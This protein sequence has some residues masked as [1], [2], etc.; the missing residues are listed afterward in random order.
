MADLTDIDEILEYLATIGISH[1]KYYNAVSLIS[2]YYQNDICYII[3]LIG[4]Y[5]KLYISHEYY[6][7][8]DNLLRYCSIGN[9]YKHSRYN[10]KI[11][12]SVYDEIF[13]LYRDEF[14]FKFQDIN[15]LITHINK[16]YPECIKQED[17][18][19]ALK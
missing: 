2:E 14:I 3:N 16:H 11:T 5:K 6:N 19:I 10:T 4:Y 8:L 9:K 18:K 15:D 13:S 7:I 1:R 17:I 12:Y